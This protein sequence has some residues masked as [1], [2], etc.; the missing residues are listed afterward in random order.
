MSVEELDSALRSF[1]GEA[2]KKNGEDYNK[3]SLLSLRNSIERK[4]NSPPYNRGIRIT[5]NVCFAKS[6]QLLDAKIKALKREG[7]QNV[8]H[9]QPIELDDLRKLKNSDAINL[10]CPLGLLR[11]VWFHT[12]LYWCRRGVEGQ[13]SLTKRSFVFEEDGNGQ[14]FATMT[15]DEVTKNHPGGISDSE[16]FEKLARMYE[17][18]HSN[19]GYQAL[20]LYL[21]KLNPLCESL[22]Q[23]PKRQWKP[24]DRVWFE[25]RPLG[26]NK[27]SSMMKV[28]SAE[29]ELSRVY[30]NH[31]IRATAI[32][33][34][35]HAG[36]NDRQIMAISGHRNEA[37]LRSYSNRPSTAQ[38]QTC[39]D[40]LSCAL[41]ENS[42]LVSRQNEQA[43]RPV[44]KP[45]NQLP[46]IGTPSLQLES[47]ASFRSTSATSRHMQ[48]S[49]LFH[50]CNI[51]NVNISFKE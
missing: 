24:A 25:N 36:L 31:C 23:Y 6:N 35:S 42:S 26:V 45:Q 9:K 19:D 13:R 22:F 48:L 18:D 37:S 39:S 4:L 20:K 17:T 30:T 16:S 1:Y 29:A 7:K 11:N 47:T 41:S 28:I 38:L 46:L 49:G 5:D 15:H 3:S 40:V 51:Q 34:W 10:T 2:R 33:L 27:L 8:Q 50:S 14:R 21:A 43:V 44:L 12:T 32:T